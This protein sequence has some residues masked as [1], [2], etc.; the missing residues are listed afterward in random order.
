MLGGHAVTSCRY[1]RN[2]IVAVNGVIV[3]CNIVVLDVEAFPRGVIVVEVVVGI[4][5]V[6]DGELPAS[7]L[8]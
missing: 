1:C 4:T 7:F 5:G 8:F 2:N 6:E 3:R